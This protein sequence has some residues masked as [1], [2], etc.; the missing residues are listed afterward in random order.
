[1]V[2]NVKAMESVHVAVA[3]NFS[4]TLKQLKADFEAKH[5]IQL[6][7][8]SAS[9]GKL[10]AQ[11]VN[12]APY[13]VFLSADKERPERLAQSGIG[14][15]RFTYAIG[16][17]VVWHPN[18]QPNS[19]NVSML[20]LDNIVRIAIANPKIAPYGLAAQQWLTSQG[21]WTDAIKQKMVR[22]E[23]V[24]QTLQFVQSGHAQIGFVA[25]S[26]LKRLASAD[27]SVLDTDSYPAIEQQAVHLN[28]EQNTLS[29][30]HYLKS[31]RAQQRIAQLG[32]RLP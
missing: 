17:L 32:Y 30:I 2:A 5:D 24:A 10:Y 22:G 13:D 20:A 29:F 15:G 7:I 27:Y 12:G 25:L 26:D 23:N 6:V 21:Q 19:F 16:Q 1:M 11:I 3:S 18:I 9:S 14:H 28:V 4:T 31:A 8:S